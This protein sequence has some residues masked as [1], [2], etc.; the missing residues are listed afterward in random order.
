MLKQL[1]ELT[2]DLLCVATIA[3]DFD[4]NRT[5]KNILEFGIRSVCK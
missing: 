2:D 4:G 1:N 5:S 3:L